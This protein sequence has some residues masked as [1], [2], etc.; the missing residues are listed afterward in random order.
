MIRGRALL[1]SDLLTNLSDMR[2]EVGDD[3]ASAFI[4]FAAL[5]LVMESRAK[6]DSGPGPTSINQFLL[7]TML[8]DF[9]FVLSHLCLI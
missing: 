8:L 3:I 1:F 9:L 7:S 4:A 5:H 2:Y 6:R